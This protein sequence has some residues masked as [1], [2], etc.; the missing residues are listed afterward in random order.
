MKL[1]ME[2]I[3]EE[4]IQIEYFENKGKEK[5]YFTFYYQGPESKYR[6]EDGRDHFRKVSVKYDELVRSALLVPLTTVSSVSVP[7]LDDNYN[8][9]PDEGFDL[10]YNREKDI[11]TFSISSWFSMSFSHEDFIKI[12]TIIRD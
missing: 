2:T 8:T 5:L 7:F 10:S 4:E 11:V 9:T 6:E 1:L 12:V 3:K